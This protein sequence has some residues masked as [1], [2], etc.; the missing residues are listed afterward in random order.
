MGG[1]ISAEPTPS[2]TE[3]PTISSGSPCASSASIPPT[4]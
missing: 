4:P 1:I 3:Y 2:S